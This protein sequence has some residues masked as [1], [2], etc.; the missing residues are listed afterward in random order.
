MHYKDL[1]GDLKADV[2]KVILS[3]FGTEDTHHIIHTPYW[4][5][6]GL[7]YFNQSIYIHSHVETPHGVKSLMAGGTWQYNP[8]TEELKVFSRGM[9]N[10]WGHKMDKFG[11]SFATDGAYR[12]GINYLF[13]GVSAI[14]A[15]GGR[16]NYKGLNRGQ[17]KQC[18]LELISGSHFPEKYRGLLVTNDF[19]GHRTNSFKVREDGS[20]Y[21]SQKQLDFIAAGARGKGSNSGS[22]RP[23]DLKMGPDGALY[24]AD[25][26]NLIIQHGEVSFRDKRRDQTHGRI[27]RITAKNRTLTKNPKLASASL[28]KLLENLKSPERWVSDMSKRR[29]IE[30]GAAKVLPLLKKWQQQASSDYHKLQALWLRVGLNAPDEAL[31]KEVMKAKD[32][33]IRAAAIRVAAHWP[34][35]LDLVSIF[36]KS[37]K[38][39]HPRVRLETINAMRVLKSVK[40]VEIAMQAPSGGNLQGW[41]WILISDPK[42]TPDSRNGRIVYAAL[43]ALGAAF[44]K[45]IDGDGNV[46][47]R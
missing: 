25:W 38:D 30:F 20:G 19:R 39:T 4:G 8:N 47:R 14:T 6:D 46:R 24:V 1:D 23:I 10:P 12:E 31:V 27:W 45:L 15:Y 11:Q 13:P 34:Q 9:I 7:L 40:A 17:P 35:A 41:R 29:L 42:T 21:T 33:R 3:G 5:Q 28:E 44:S 37:I 2:K 43:V 32:G 22:F 26:S 18:G 36:K 16:P